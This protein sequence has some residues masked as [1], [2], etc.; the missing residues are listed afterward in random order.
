MVA[1]LVFP[2]RN[3]AGGSGY[4]RVKF[5]QPRRIIGR[6]VKYE[7]PR[8]RPNEIYF[9]P[10]TLPSLND[11]TVPLLITEGEKKSLAADQNALPCI[12]LVGVFGWKAAGGEQLLSGLERIAWQHRDVRIVFDSDVQHNPEIQAAEARLAVQLARRGALVRVVRLPDGPPGADGQPT[13]MGLDD[14]IVAHGL[15]ALRALLDAAEDP[16]E[17]A[18]GVLRMPAK[19][20]NPREVVESFLEI[21]SVE[22]FPTLRYWQGSWFEWVDGCYIE[23]S[24]NEMHAQLV[25]HLNEIADN[26]TTG[27]IGNHFAQLK[28]LALLPDSVTSPTWIGPDPLPWDS[29]E[30]MACRRALVHLPSLAAN[31]PEYSRPTSP[32]YFNTIAFEYDFDPVAPSPDLWLGFLSQLW[33]NDPFSIAVLQ[34]WF[35]YCLVPDTRQQKILMLVGPGRSGKGTIARLLRKLIGQKNAVGPTMA[36]FGKRFGLSQLL[37]KS[38][39]TISDARLG[40]RTDSSVVVERLLSISGENRSPSTEKARTP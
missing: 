14:F 8:G 28:A 24:E 32:W 18:G 34:E 38:V 1:A 17:P 10:N 9:P 30:V 29:R 37:N 22:S 13:K 31:L 2:F 20:L 40:H 21:R 7:S 11:P 39:A 25:R 5:D 36:S 23:R 33:P 16:A 4:A 12:G 19:L 15:P 26:L 3:S 6:V 35:G 27:G